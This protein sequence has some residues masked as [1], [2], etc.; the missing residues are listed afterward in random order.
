MSKTEPLMKFGL[1]CVIAKPLDNEDLKIETNSVKCNGYAA[2]GGLRRIEKVQVCLV[3]DRSESLENLLDLAENEGDWNEA[4]LIGS[5]K[6]SWRLFE[7][8]LSVPSTKIGKVA[9]IARAGE[10][11]FFCKNEGRN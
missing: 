7:I 5:G 10:W 1:Q 11:L 9:F 8:K 4:D 2:V 6:F 3:Q